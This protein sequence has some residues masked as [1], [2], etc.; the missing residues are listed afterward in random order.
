MS[1]EALPLRRERTSASSIRR[2][3]AA[4][5]ASP[6]HGTLGR[7]CCYSEAGLGARPSVRRQCGP[8]LF[9]AQPELAKGKVETAPAIERGLFFSAHPTYAL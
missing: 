9:G 5:L 3:R 8:R 4:E 7:Y 2:L 6:Q 1:H